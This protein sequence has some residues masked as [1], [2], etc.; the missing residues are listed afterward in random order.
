MFKVGEEVCL[1][2]GKKHIYTISSVRGNDVQVSEVREVW[3]PKD[4]F[5]K[6]KSKVINRQVV[7]NRVP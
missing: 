6:I 4:L 2:S 3:Y 1:A 7:R 5:C